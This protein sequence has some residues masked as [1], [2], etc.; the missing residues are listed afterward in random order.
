MKNSAADNFTAG[1]PS[2]KGLFL[3][4]D[5]QEDLEEEIVG[6]ILRVFESFNFSSMSSDKKI[7]FIKEM[8][9]TPVIEEELD[10]SKKWLAQLITARIE[11]DNPCLKCFGRGC[12]ECFWTGKKRI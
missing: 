4:A 12:D 7:S 6:E 9:G 1:D 11:T 3:S 10:K 5:K 2:N 8:F